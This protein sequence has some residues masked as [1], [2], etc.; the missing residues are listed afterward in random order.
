MLLEGPTFKENG[1]AVLSPIIIRILKSFGGG[2]GGHGSP[3]YNVVL[4]WIGYNLNLRRDKEL[5]RV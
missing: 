1:V 2:E 4:P 5:T 3:T